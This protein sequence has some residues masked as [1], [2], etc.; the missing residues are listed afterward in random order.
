MKF[1]TPDMGELIEIITVEP[2]GN[3]VIIKGKIMGTMPMKVVLLPEELRHGFKFLTPRLVLTLI[4][5]LFRRTK[6]S[7]LK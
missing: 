7:L 6:R 5:M 4:T 3:S 2:D 1:F